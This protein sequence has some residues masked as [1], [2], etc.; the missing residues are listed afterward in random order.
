LSGLRVNRA[1]ERT[2]L[3]RASGKAYTLP[4]HFENLIHKERS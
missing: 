2:R 1:F 4:L 3:T